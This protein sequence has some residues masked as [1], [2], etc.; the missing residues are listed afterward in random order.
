ML[1]V[2]LLVFLYKRYVERHICVYVCMQGSH[3]NTAQHR[4]DTLE[5]YVLEPALA[6]MRVDNTL[7]YKPTTQTESI[8]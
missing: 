4:K 1:Y 3:K 6:G 5:T 2:S 8:G 7:M